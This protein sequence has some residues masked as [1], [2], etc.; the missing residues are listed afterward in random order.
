MPRLK[1]MQNPLFRGKTL[2]KGYRFFYCLYIIFAN[3]LLG[4][5]IFPMLRSRFPD[6]PIFRAGRFLFYRPNPIRPGFFDC[7]DSPLL[8]SYMEPYKPR[9]PDSAE[10]CGSLGKP[11]ISAVTRPTRPPP[12]A[13]RNPM[14]A[15][16]CQIANRDSPIF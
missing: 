15:S 13:V 14:G 6:C 7:A 1:Q 5:Q 11:R 3:R 10:R 2:F 9:F 4:R 8:K 12:V 16:Y